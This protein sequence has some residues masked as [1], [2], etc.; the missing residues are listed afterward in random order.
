MENVSPAFKSTSS[1]AV[2]GDRFVP[3]LFQK[4]FDVIGIGARCVDY[5]AV[6]SS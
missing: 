5:L 4:E 1:P 3:D 6:V 2:A